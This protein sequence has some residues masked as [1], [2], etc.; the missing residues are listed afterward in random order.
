M[1]RVTN[2]SWDKKLKE[3]YINSVSFPENLP[4][5]KSIE[6]IKITILENYRF[7]FG[8]EI[9]LVFMIG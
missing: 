1:G 4:I 5:S 9:I 2:N 6:D 8:I 7:F 3:E